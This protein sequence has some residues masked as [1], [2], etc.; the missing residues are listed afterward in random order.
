MQKIDLLVVG[1]HFYTMQG[2]GV[3][4]LANG[5]MAVDRGRI[6]AIGP[7]AEIAGA[8]E[9]TRTL[10]VSGQAVFPGLIDAH[11][12]TRLGILR[13]LA[14]DTNYWMMYG[15]GPFSNAL[16]SQEDEAALEAG[17]QLA[18]VEGLRAGTTT[19]GD[20]G[21][22][23]D[24]TCRFIEKIGVRGRITVTIREAVRRVYNPGELYEFDESYG[25][26]TLEENLAVFAHWH[27]GA[28][29]RISVLFGPQGPD[30][31]SKELLLKVRQ[32]ALERQT[33]IHMHTQQGDRETAQVMQRYGKRPIAWLDEIGFL[34]KN[35]LAVHLTDA[36]EEEA[37][38]VARRGASMVLC[39][40]SIGIIDGIVPPAK[41]FQ[42]AGGNV[43]LGSDQAPGNNCHNILNEMKLTAL[44]NKIRYSNPEVMPAWKVLRMA[45]IEGARAIGLGEQ[46]GSLEEGKRA[47][48][49]LVDLAKPSMLPVFTEPMR[50]IVPNLVYSARGDEVT[51]VVVDG[52]VV[53]EQGK[54][55]T[56]DEAEIL[57]RVQELAKP[58][59]PQAAPEFWQINGTNA[60]FMRKDKL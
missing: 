25:N 54:I 49:I 45:T 55:Q 57:K 22:G 17:S 16:E 20:F 56:V 28:N 7:Q 19:F 14:Q 12:H 38:L 46:I 23:M 15:L 51:T 30:F 34:D 58:V 18:I 50:N 53:Y 39:S 40:G 26:E 21:N 2:E 44:F 47:D 59:G 5:A 43:A 13:G 24:A 60:L 1:P 36:N 31:L 3:G 8:Y 10:D 4:Y 6:L 32:L 35:L 42:D 37:A 27:N 33:M 48:F 41:A 52:Q 11:M 9:A 29:G